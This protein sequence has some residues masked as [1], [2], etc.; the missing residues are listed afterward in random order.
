MRNSP[1]SSAVSGKNYYSVSSDI[2]M[3]IFMQKST[4][5]APCSQVFDIVQKILSYQNPTNIKTISRCPVH[6]VQPVQCTFNKALW[7]ICPYDSSPFSSAIKY[8]L[9]GVVRMSDCNVYICAKCWYNLALVLT[10]L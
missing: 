8:R 2:R 10:P 9:L 6:S 4:I 5:L 1:L 7:H 3:G